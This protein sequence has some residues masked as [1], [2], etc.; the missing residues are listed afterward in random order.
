MTSGRPGPVLRRL[1]RMPTLLYRGNLGWLLGERFL[2]LTHVGRRSRRRYRTVLEVVARLP[3]SDELVVLAGFGRAADWLRNAEAGGAREV[4]VGRRRF[5]PTVRVL[6]EDGA[7]Q[8]LAS[9]ELRNRLIRPVLHQILSRLVCWPYLGTDDQRPDWFANCRWSPW[10]RP[11][12]LAGTTPRAGRA[13]LGVTASPV[14][15]PVSAR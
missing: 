14:R 6:A 11:T 9:Y 3:V 10:G 15:Q 2:M 8:V 1:L 7:T 5:P 4:T 12:G 13:A